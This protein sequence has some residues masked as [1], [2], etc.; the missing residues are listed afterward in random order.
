MFTEFKFI[1]ILMVWFLKG[2]ELKNV[3]SKKTENN[4]MF[5]WINTSHDFSDLDVSPFL[6]YSKFLTKIKVT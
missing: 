2:D 1:L 5:S 4:E 3:K 6:K